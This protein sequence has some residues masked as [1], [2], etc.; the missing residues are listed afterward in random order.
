[1][2]ETAEANKVGKRYVCA[3]CSSE[4]IVTKSGTGQVQPLTCHGQVMAQ[5]G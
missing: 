3:V 2:A 5:K 4:F 1:M